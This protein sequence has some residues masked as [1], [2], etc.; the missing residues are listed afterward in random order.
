MGVGALRW[1]R[2]VIR[3]FRLSPA[4]SRQGVS[5]DTSGAF[6][7]NVS[8]LKRSH[9]HGKDHWEPRDCNELSKA[10]G[11]SFG[12][13]IDMSSKVGGLKAICN[14]LND[15]DIARA[16]IATVLLGIPDPPAFT[17]DRHSHDRMIKFIRD[18]Y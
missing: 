15:G 4:G 7:A 9:K 12:L 1:E 14:A 10:I 2:Q 17:K 13:P 11:S 8:L 6:I 16:Q 18:L 5:C 3:E